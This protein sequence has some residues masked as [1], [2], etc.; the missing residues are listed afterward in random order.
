MSSV[1][2]LTKSAAQ[3]L[4]HRE[5]RRIGSRMV[6]YEVVAQTVG[7]SADWIRKFVNG[8]DGAKRPD[9]EVGFNLMTVYSRICERVEQA[10]ANEMQL[11]EDIDAALES[12]ALLVD[13]PEAADRSAEASARVD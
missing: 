9:V 4:V 3:A 10:G 6:A 7:A 13:Q 12:A 8:Y 5:E 1:T 11:K 2:A